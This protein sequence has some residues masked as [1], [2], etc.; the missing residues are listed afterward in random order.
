[1]QSIITTIKN[2][3]DIQ[4]LLKDIEI[5][6]KEIIILTRGEN[7]DIGKGKRNYQVH[8]LEGNF[9][10]TLKAIKNIFDDVE[11]PI[12]IAGGNELDIYL[13]YYLTQFS[14]ETPM[15]VEENNRPI[16]VPI[17]SSHGFVSTKRKI[18]EILSKRGDVSFKYIQDNL[19]RQTPRTKHGRRKFSETTIN[20]Y[21]HELENMDLIDVE[22]KRNKKYSLN[23]RGAHYID[24]LK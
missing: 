4:N 12:F 24:L 6:P 22:M 14:K 20:Q 7:I 1:M 18:L 10:E 13:T 19:S 16:L 17:S 15:Y 23:D 3:E 9:H 5:E 8:R 2:P 11:D 21:L